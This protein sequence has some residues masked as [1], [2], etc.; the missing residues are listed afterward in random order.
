[1]SKKKLVFR[2]GQGL[3]VTGL[4]LTLGASC[5]KDTPKD[6]PNVNTVAPNSNPGAQTNGQTNQADP[7]PT[8]PPPPEIN[9]NTVET[10]PLTTDMGTDADSIKLAPEI[11]VNT[12]AP[13][14]KPE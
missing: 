14:K 2:V 3:A 5:S 10:P 13:K 9:V 7:T 11:R 8:P 6:G 12:P 1:M 4:A